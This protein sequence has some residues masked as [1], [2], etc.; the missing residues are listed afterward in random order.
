[1]ST[2]RRKFSKEFKVKVVLESL[3][4]RNPLFVQVWQIADSRSFSAIAVTWT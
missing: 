2:I 4:E 1:M 3:K